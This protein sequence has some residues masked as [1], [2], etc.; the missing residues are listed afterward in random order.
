MLHNFEYEHKLRVGVIGAGEHCYRNILPCFQYAPV[1][2]ITLSDPQ[3]ERG[4]AV[5]RQFGAR[6]FYPNHK[7]MLAKE[8]LDAVFIVVGPD[9]NGRPQYPE[10]AADSLRAGCHTWIDVPPCS[11]SDELSKFTNAC[12]VKRKYVATGFKKM[13]M[14]SYLKVAEIIADPAFGEIS[15]F[16]MRY[17]LTLPAEDQRNDQAA[18]APFL[19]FVQPYAALLRLFGECEGFSYLRSKA[20]GDVVLN[21]RYRKGFVGTLHLCGSQALTSPIERLEVIGSGA[22]VV[23][24]NG[25]RLVYYRAGGRRGDTGNKNTDSYIGPDESAPIVWEPEFSLG[26]VYNKQLFLEGYAG[27]VLAF[28]ER[29]LAGE[30][31]KHGNLVDMLHIMNV[32]DKIRRGKEQVWI[33][34]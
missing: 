10:L 8:E 30:A 23:V 18:M 13:F 32:H 4:L 3:A 31:P 26:K 24:E 2:L 5:A 17:P 11:G 1:E 34:A 29:L 16:S 33:T 15:S 9:A 27:A 28:A 12:M 7:T 21:L 25:V 19:G 22:N 6:H 14:P 20:T